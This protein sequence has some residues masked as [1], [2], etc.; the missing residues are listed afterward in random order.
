MSPRHPS[1]P[2]HLV[3]LSPLKPLSPISPCHP[4]HPC[5][6]VTSSPFSPLQPCHPVTLETLV[7]HIALS[8]LPALSP[9]HQYNLATLVTL[10]PSLPFST[11]HL[12]HLVP[13]VNTGQRACTM[14]RV[15]PR[16]KITIPYTMYHVPTSAILL[17]VAILGA[18]SGFIATRVNIVTLL[19]LPVPPLSLMLPSPPLSALYPVLVPRYHCYQCHFVMCH[20]CYPFLSFHPCLGGIAPC[21]TVQK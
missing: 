14:Y 8:P 6:L 9:C 20:H 13:L 2:C 15:I 3:T 4:S 19:S 18:S 7:T 10:S 16:W 1:H 21:T 17:S 12:C 11:C 5:H